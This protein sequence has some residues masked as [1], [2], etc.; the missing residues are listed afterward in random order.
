MRN[1]LRSK[2]AMNDKIK[3]FHG[4]GKYSGEIMD[5]NFIVG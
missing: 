4:D 1:T 5:I 3:L 2:Y